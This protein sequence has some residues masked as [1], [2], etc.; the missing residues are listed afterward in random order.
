METDTKTS[1]AKCGQTGRHQS[2]VTNSTFVIDTDFRRAT[3][4]V[5][6]KPAAR[7]PPSIFLHAL[8]T[9]AASKVEEKHMRKSTICRPAALQT[10]H[11]KEGTFQKYQQ[12]LP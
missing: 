8:G 5:A 4:T 2:E 1:G 6:D 10:D 3:E 9:L 11:Q 12:Q 7:S